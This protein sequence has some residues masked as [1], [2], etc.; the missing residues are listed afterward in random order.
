M[1]TP[2]QP[3]VS[4]H[5][6]ALSSASQSQNKKNLEVTGGL[7]VW[8]LGE[9]FD[10]QVYAYEFGLECN[11][12]DY[13]RGDDVISGLLREL[14]QYDRDE[15]T[16]LFPQLVS[17]V[18]CDYLMYGRCMFELFN[19]MDGDATGPHLGILPGWSLRHRW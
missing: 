17:A 6:W 18:A 1:I 10:H 4:T 15:A 13:Q 8:M 3:R 2:L 9:D 14:N 11:G 7:N 19:D 16:A 5:H 12:V